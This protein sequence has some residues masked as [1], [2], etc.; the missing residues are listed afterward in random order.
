MLAVMHEMQ[1]ER[2]N[3]QDHGAQGTHIHTAVVGNQGPLLCTQGRCFAQ[4]KY[5]HDPLTPVLSSWWLFLT[6]AHPTPWTSCSG[7][8]GW[9]SLCHSHTH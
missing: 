6:I 5:K 8:E 3:K 7:P 1:K 9:V 2:A 4:A